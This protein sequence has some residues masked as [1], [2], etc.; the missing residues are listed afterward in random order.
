MAERMVAAE[1][2]VL[3]V[4][5]VQ[6]DFCENGNLVVP[7]IYPLPQPAPNS[8][9]IKQLRFTIAN[10][11]F[12]PII[13][14]KARQAPSSIN[15]S[16]SRMRYWCCAR[17]CIAQSIPIPPSTRMIAGHPPVFSDTCEK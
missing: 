10:K 4:V 14:S 6:N 7:R 13:V 8:T 15:C 9:L 5:D 16:R 12:G 11:S 17:E 2:D 1:G 3:I